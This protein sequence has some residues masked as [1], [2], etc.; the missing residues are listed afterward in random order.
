MENFD[1]SI[2][3]EKQ[4]IFCEQY[5][6]DWNASRAAR[7]AGYSED[8]AKVIGSENLTKPNIQAYI[9]QLKKETGR[10][11]GVSILRNVL[12]LKKI[13][14]SNIA[15][16]KESWMTE[17]EFDELT[18]DQKGALSEINYEIRHTKEGESKI[19]KFKMHDKIKAIEVMNK[20]LGLNAP[21]KLEVDPGHK[22]NETFGTV[23]DFLLSNKNKA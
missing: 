1:S 16:L 13:A 3:T 12:E 4:R 23:A 18:E 22:S 17:K 7:F 19:V 11:A 21:D 6:I 14:Y 10:L 8:T 9:E 15:D 20:M 5:V 2:L